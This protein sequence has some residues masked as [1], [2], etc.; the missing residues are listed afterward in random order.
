MYREPHILTNYH[1]SH[2]QRIRPDLTDEQAQAVLRHVEDKWD[3]SDG[4]TWEI[5]IEHVEILF[6]EENDDGQQFFVFLDV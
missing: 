4:V 5:L 1:F 6:P 2:I 3:T